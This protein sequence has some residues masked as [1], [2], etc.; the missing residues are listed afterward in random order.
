LKEGRIRYREDIAEGLENTPGAFI[1]MLKGESN[2]K[3]LVKV[4]D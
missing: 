2:G 3:Q 1:R 4:A